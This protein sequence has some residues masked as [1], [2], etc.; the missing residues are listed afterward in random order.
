[1]GKNAAQWLMKNLEYFV[2]E[3][4]P[5]L[6][7]SFRDSGSAYTLQRST[8]SFGQFLLLTELKVGGYRRSV[9]IPVGKEKNGWRVFGLELRK[10]LNPSHYAEGGAGLPTF[11]SQVLRPSWEAQNSRTFA[12]VVQ[13]S[14]GSA[15]ERKQLKQL[16]STVKE[17]MVVKPRPTGAKVGVLLV[18]KP[19]KLVVGG[20]DRRK[21]RI[22]EET[23]VGEQNQA[24]IRFPCLSLNSKAHRKESDV[25]RPCWT[26]S[27]LIVE[28]DVIGRRLVSWVRKK[29]GVQ[30]YKW[31]SRVGKE[32]CEGVLGLGRIKLA[33]QLPVNESETWSGP[34]VTSPSTFEEGECSIKVAE[35]ILSV[36]ILEKAGESPEASSSS[37]ELPSQVSGGL[38]W[39]ST[40]RVQAEVQA[41]A[42]QSQTESVHN[43]SSPCFPV[44]RCFVDCVLRINSSIQIG[45]ILQINSSV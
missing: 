20:G 23:E 36:V 17:K 8:N 10:M 14:F 38:G 19:V 24:G 22:N 4:S 2:V 25:R 1:M 35:P 16:G 34:E 31:V 30:K 27:G 6:F 39:P 26:G 45:C 42:S 3:V 41:T 13:D 32:S 29:G 37:H 33:T 9:I 12:E 5:K 40:V 44:L 43:F 15:V 28:V 21:L 7:F 18:G 11:I